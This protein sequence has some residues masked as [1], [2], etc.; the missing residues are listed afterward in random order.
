MR[1]SIYPI[2]YY[3]QKALQRVLYRFSS[4]YKIE[5]NNFFEAITNEKYVV[6]K[7]DTPNIHQNFPINYKIGTDIDLIVLDEDLQ[8]IKNK[9]LELNKDKN[10]SCLVFENEKNIKIRYQYYRFLNL[11]FDLTVGSINQLYG[12]CLDSLNVKGNIKIPEIKYELAIRAMEFQ[13][14]PY[15][16]HHLNYLVKNKNYIDFDLLSNSGIQFDTIEKIKSA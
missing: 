1:I 9:I 4:N 13:N 15:K 6:V 2:I 12:D 7:L 3:T 8:I 11:Q 14:K 5:V 16:K 10:L